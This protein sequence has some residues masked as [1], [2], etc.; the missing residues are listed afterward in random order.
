M[1]DVTTTRLDYLRHGQPIGGQRFRG[2]G[3]DDPLSGLG[4]RQMRETA[5]AISSW[6]RVITSPMQ[7]CAA[8]AEWLATQRGLP[9]EVIDDLREVGFGAWEGADRDQLKRERAEEYRAFYAD[10]VGNRPAG[11]EPLDDLGQRV[12]GVFDDLGRRFRG[13]NLLVVAHAGVIRAT[14]GHVTRMPAANW[15]RVLVDNAAVTRFRIDGERALLIAHNWRPNI[16]EN[17]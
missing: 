5:A 14:L 11:A 16:Q 4:W 17:P 7:R 3:I 8:F 6:Q 12:G 9:L 1:N 13:E 10:P 2:N 15:Y